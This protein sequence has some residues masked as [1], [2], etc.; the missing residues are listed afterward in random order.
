M[1]SIPIAPFLVAIAMVA[2]L[3]CAS[4]ATVQV[5]ST[6]TPPPPDTPVLVLDKLESQLKLIAEQ[7]SLG[8]T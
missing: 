6:P 4:N 5:P 2:G 1:S 7:R 3:G 8:Y